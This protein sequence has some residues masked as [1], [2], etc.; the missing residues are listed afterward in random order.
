MKVKAEPMNDA[1]RSWPFD[2]SRYDRRKS[3][4]K[5]EQRGLAAATCAGRLCIVPNRRLLG[6]LIVPLFLHGY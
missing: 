5:K 4:S 6:R 1:E 2:L 3:L